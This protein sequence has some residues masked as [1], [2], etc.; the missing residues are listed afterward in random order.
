MLFFAISDFWNLTPG[1]TFRHLGSEVRGGNAIESRN[2]AS[3]RSP[4]VILSGE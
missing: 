4:L 2:W 1:G 3:G